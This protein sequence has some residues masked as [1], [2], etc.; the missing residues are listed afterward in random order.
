MQLVE[1]ILMALDSIRANKMRALLT[2]LGIIIGIS[3]VIAVMSI[4]DS[5]TGY[6]SGQWQEMGVNNI[7]LNVREKPQEVE[8]ITMSPALLLGGSSGG[9]SIPESD[10]LTEENL[11]LLA[12]RFG[13]EIEAISYTESIGTGKI[14]EGKLYANVSVSGVS[15]G[16]KEVNN[17][18]MIQGGFISD[19][20]MQ[21]GKSVAIISDKAAENLFKNEDPIMQEVKVT[22]NDKIY[23]FTVVGVYKYEESAMSAMMGAGATSD[24]DKE[25]NLYIPVTTAKQLNGNKNYAS[26]TVMGSQ[27]VAANVLSQKIEKYFESYYRNSSYE[28]SAMSIESQLEMM[29]S[30]LDMIKLA[31]AII[32][33]ISLV[34]GGVGVMNIMLVSVTERTRE[35]GTRKA[36]GAKKG[37]IRMQFV[38]EAVIISLIGGII[39][40]LLGLGLS[41]IVANVIVGAFELDLGV[42]VSCMLFSMAIGIFFGYYPAN[43][44]A[45]LDPIEALRYE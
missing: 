23:T 17:I 35:I 40:V 15:P 7:Y 26:V 18:K 16:Y 37:Q 38:C 6:V 13:E 25:T 8:S 14:R 42:I 5:L 44:A 41:I 3:S 34:V 31:I 27:S 43:K 36:L 24:K 10:L 45:G 20:D 28:I 21:K 11:E 33:G 32:A 12:N 22:V 30:M 19:L 9:S 39:G 1:N 4:G 29:E 2:M